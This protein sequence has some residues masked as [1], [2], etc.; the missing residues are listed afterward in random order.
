MSDLSRFVADHTA[1]N[2]CR[3]GKCGD[4]GDPNVFLL[5]HTVNMYFFDVCSVNNPLKEEFLELIA[6]HSGDFNDMNPL[7]G[8]HS[9]I[10]VGGWIGDQGIGLQFMALG[11]LLGLWE[12]MQ[13]GMILNINDPR[14]K[15]LADQMAGM[16]MVSIIQSSQKSG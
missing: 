8:E 5:P 12:I 10:E 11:K 7:E 14:Q 1:R 16:G 9:Y 2:A 3:C 4:P 15:Q 13:P 6:K